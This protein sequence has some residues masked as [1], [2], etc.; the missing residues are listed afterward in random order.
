MKKFNFPLNTV[1]NYKDQVLDNLKNEHAQ[2]VDQ[3]VRQ[4]K[5]G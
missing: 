5:K 2:I 4:E 3:V 1:L